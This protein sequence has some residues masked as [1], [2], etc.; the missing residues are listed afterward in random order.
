MWLYEYERT[1]PSGEQCAGR[2]DQ[3]RVMREM[4]CTYMMD[5]LVAPPISRALL[6]CM[7]RP[8]RMNIVFC[9]P[10]VVDDSP[11]S[12][13]ALSSKPASDVMEDCQASYRHIEGS[14]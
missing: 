14:L 11:S 7:P 5:F 6:L 9:A 13:Y 2:K 10:L 8:S 12:I 1:G 3:T 4:R